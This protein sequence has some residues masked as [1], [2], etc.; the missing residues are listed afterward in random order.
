MI[1]Q[2]TS[3][4]S[5]AF[6]LNSDS[7]NAY[8]MAARAAVIFLVAL[9]L[10]RVGEKRFI[11]KN[12]AFDVVLGVMLGSLL[13]TAVTDSSSFFN[14]M[15]AGAVFVFLHWLL[16]VISFHSDA[17][18][19][20]LKGRDRQLIKDGEIDWDEMRESH[21]TKND[22]VSALRRQGR[23]TDPSEVKAAFLERNGDISVIRE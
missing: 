19:S 15:V 21:V 22:L 11:G 5:A 18:G 10:V 20:V 4:I 6:G 14:I 9:A 17:V 13:S 7:I 23:M 16:A 3:W 8:Q 1:E 2:L 12:T